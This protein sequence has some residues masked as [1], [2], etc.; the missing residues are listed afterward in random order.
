M[1]KVILIV[2][3]LALVG[4]VAAGVFFIRAN[5]KYNEEIESAVIE[6][7]SAA[8]IELPVPEIRYGMVVDSFRVERAKVC[9]N[10]TLEK[11]LGRYN[12]APEVINQI[13]SSS[14]SIYDL[15][16]IQVG[17]SYTVFCSKEGT[18]AKCFV[19]K[20]N[21]MEHVVVKLDTAVHV[22]MADIK[23]DTTVRTISGVINSSFYETL[24]DN[25]ATPD[26][27]SNLARV[28]AWQVD[29]FRIFKGDHFKVIYEE[30]SV[31]GKPIKSGKILAAC[32]NQ[33]GKNYYAFNFE[34]DGEEKFFNEEGKNVKGAFLRAP[35]KYFRITSRFTKKRFHPVQKRYKA[36][37]G[38]D[39]A[40]PTGTPI[41]AVGSGTVVEARYSKF[42]GNYVKI[43]HNSTYTTQYLHMSKI[44]KGMRPGKK[45]AQGQVIGYVGS[46]GLAT[47][48][49]VCFRF[50]EN[51]RQVDHTKVK[52]VQTDPLKKENT[53]EF[54]KLKDEMIKKLDEIQLQNLDAVAKED[55]DQQGDS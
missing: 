28:F 7:D 9:R 29:F 43:K 24:L 12:V 20:A 3:S 39:Y 37:L 2:L 19:Y 35:L 36:H 27:A 52:V 40:A 50:W 53:A 26:M 44:A 13:A 6:T 31:D 18:D 25:N 48:P 15:S 45:I 42:N 11:I 47:G 33:Y 8:V 22:Y 21:P 1:K 55:S 51:G 30:I 38:T 34:E 16:R 5:I 41:V 14:K 23:V 4:A 17:K 49:H 32:F 10:E 54:N 46:T